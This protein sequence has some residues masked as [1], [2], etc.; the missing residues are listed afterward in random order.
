MADSLILP[1][2]PTIKDYQ[3]YISRMVKLRGFDKE[4]L[5]E[6]MLLMV[7][8]VGE[9][10]KVVRKA[11][12]LHVDP[13]SVESSAEEELADIFIYLLDLAN[14]L[15]VDLEKAFRQKEAKNKK[16]AWKV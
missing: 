12:G 11:H 1:K 9:L 15:D 10:A 7:E 6:I 8:E 3:T 13:K 14:N 4:S 2:K 16:R 5:P